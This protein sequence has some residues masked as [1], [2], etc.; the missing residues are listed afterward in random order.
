MLTPPPPAPAGS[1]ATRQRPHSHGSPSLLSTAI[2]AATLL[3]WTAASVPRAA[4]T[5]ADAIVL[6][7]SASARFP[8]FQRFIQPYLENFGVPYS[9]FDIHTNALDSSIAQHALIIVGHNQLDTTGQYLGDA[10]QQTLEGAVAGGAGLVNFD[11]SFPVAGQAPTNQFVQAIFGFTY[12][13]A[14]SN[15]S[16]T[17]P[18]TEA[19][20]SMHYVTARHPAGE[21]IPLSNSLTVAG[22]R[23]T[24]NET[25]LATS[26]GQPLVVVTK[27]GQ[28]RA[29]QWASYDWM[30]TTVQGPLNGL[31][32]LIWRGMVWAARKPFAM[33][34][35][36]N[37][38]TMRVDDCEGPFWWTHTA[39][40]VGFKPWIGLFINNVVETNAADVRAMAATGNLT[41]SLHSMSSSS[42]CYWNQAAGTNWSDS[43]VSNNIYLGGLWYTNHG[44]PISKVVVPHYTE[45]GPNAFAG[46]RR[47]GVEFTTLSIDPGTA[48][49]APWLVGAPYRL[50][51]ARRPGSTFLPLHYS[52][53]LRVPGH[54]EL[55]GQIFNCVTEIRDSFNSGESNCG[56]WCPSPDIAATINRGTRTLKRAFDSQVLATLFTHEW[57]I[58]TT[59][60]CG[61][62]PI[63]PASWTAIL[64]GITNNIAAYQPIYVTLDY[65]CQY[66]RATRTSR[67]LSSNYDPVAGRLSAALSGYTDLDTSIFVYAGED[68]GI[69]ATAANIPMFNGATNA[70]LA[71]YLPPTLS[72][73]PTP[74]NTLVLSWPYPSPGFTLRQYPTTTSTNGTP[75]T[76]PATIIGDQNQVV[77]PISDGNSFYRLVK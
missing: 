7:N 20:G 2:F 64:Q 41:S 60:C 11:S 65:A 48:W 57:Y 18:A 24:N 75:V 46:L 27:F 42:L 16:V 67:M 59:S 72:I 5:G 31:D 54:P 40:N 44:I 35:M 70:L 30:S 33:R 32:D 66:V 10:G 73:A 63:P 6:V 47:W 52:H 45:I 37:F 1:L 50:S 14:S 21:T 68:S 28:G 69:T 49:G 19:G 12:L 55:D 9:V 38:V 51:E 77:L 4:A 26:G 3:L 76:T 8:D 74:S 13:A 25:V 23:L 58:H 17:F 71:A 15:A 22:L 62:S 36:P 53:F 39:M 34:G 56:E 29:L 43:V 61:S